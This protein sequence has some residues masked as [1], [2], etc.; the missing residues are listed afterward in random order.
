MIRYIYIFL[1]KIISID[2]YTRLQMK[3][4][5]AI[6]NTRLMRW[7]FTFLGYKLGCQQI[8]TGGITESY[9][10]S[11]AQIQF[12]HLTNSTVTLHV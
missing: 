6:A 5:K 9:R 12:P 2:K 10:V 4:A 11:A 1:I 3:Y 8:N 7:I